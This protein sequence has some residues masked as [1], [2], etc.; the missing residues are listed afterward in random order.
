[1]EAL[2]SLYPDLSIGGFI[3]IDDFGAVPGCRQAVL[4]YRQNHHIREEIHE[5]DWEAVFWRRE[6]SVERNGPRL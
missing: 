1:M 6:A 2:E 3:I 4:D 5:I